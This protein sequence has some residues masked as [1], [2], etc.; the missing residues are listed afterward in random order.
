QTAIPH[1]AQ[2]ST[3]WQLK[4]NLY[5]AQ[6]EI[7]KEKERNA[8]LEEEVRR[9]QQFRNSIQAELKEQKTKTHEAEIAKQSSSQDIVKIQETYKTHLGRL[10]EELRQAN[11]QLASY[12]EECEHYQ[13]KIAEF[14]TKLA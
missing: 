8:T 7:R 9:L 14:P 12:A 2:D 6:N 11:L 3:T 10:E 13:L 4:Q 5:Q 1:E